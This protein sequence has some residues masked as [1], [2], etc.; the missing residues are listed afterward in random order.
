MTALV[1]RTI[2]G[3]V[4]E[5]ASES[6]APG[7]GSSAAL[8]GSIAAGL[9]GMVCRLS[10]DKQGLAAT[11]AEL[12]AAMKETDTLRGRLLELVD[13]DTAAFDCVMDAIRMPKT[14]DEEKAARREALAAATLYAARVPRETLHACRRVLDA[15]ASLAGRAN[16]A[17]ASDLGAAVELAR[18]GAEGA[19][20]NVA[21]N[22]A[23]LPAG[24]DVDELRR[25]ADE[26][27]ALA[28]GRAE[29]AS[30]TIRAEVGLT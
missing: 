30:R 1:D 4:D 12:T 27:I 17:A 2:A 3:F 5:V 28:R 11:P 29:A 9:V 22:I 7:G 26:E 14:T 8:A 16:P 25:V 18:A 6:P 23:S 13:E 24:D 21:I 19:L 15:A 20:L 10:L